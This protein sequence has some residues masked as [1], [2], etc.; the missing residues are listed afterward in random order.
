[1]RPGTAAHFENKQ[2]SNHTKALMAGAE[3]LTVESAIDH[4]ERLEVSESAPFGRDSTSEVV[5][6]RRERIVAKA[7]HRKRNWELLGQFSCKKRGGGVSN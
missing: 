4:I 3:R 7:E 2:I 5:E 6:R 1:M